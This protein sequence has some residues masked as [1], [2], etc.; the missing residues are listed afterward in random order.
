[1]Y[2]ENL[3]GK[4]SNTMLLIYF[5]YSASPSFGTK[6][7]AE[8]NF[9]RLGKSQKRDRCLLQSQM[10][11]RCIQKVP[12]ACFRCIQEVLL[13]IQKVPFRN[14]GILVTCCD[15]KDC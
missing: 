7:K 15:T 5:Q 10:K 9:H 13:S 14:G 8:K 6:L 4:L 3:T 1:M 12:F 11:I 2:A